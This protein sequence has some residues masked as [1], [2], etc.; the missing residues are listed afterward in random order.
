MRYVNQKCPLIIDF[1]VRTLVHQEAKN[2]SS[3]RRCARKRV[4]DGSILRSGYAPRKYKSRERVEQ[5]VRAFKK[6]RQCKKSDARLQNG[7][8]KN[9]SAHP[10]THQQQYGITRLAFQSF[11][12]TYRDARTPHSTQRLSE[13]R[14][15][16][17]V[18]DK[19]VN[20]PTR[21]TGRERD[22]Y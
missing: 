20:L 19:R 12:T 13:Q 16:L 3:Y 4:V 21:E 18:S 22:L 5:S 7:G 6:P 17:R 14:V 11:L 2:E 15:S 8:P 1:L 9:T 10:P